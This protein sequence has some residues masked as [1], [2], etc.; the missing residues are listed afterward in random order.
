ME[1]RAADVAQT[2][3]TT[4]LDQLKQYNR[5]WAARKLAIDPGFSSGWRPSKR[6]SI[7]GSA[8]LAAGYR[9]MRSSVSTQ[10]GG[11]TPQSRQSRATAGRQLALEILGRG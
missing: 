6:P 4:A 8:A 3:E 9:R 11:Y 7:Y 2:T 10:E 1:P 5:A